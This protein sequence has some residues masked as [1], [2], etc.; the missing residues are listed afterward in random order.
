MSRFDAIVVGQGL[1]GTALT[2]RLLWRGLRV[3]VIDSDA[4][5]SPSKIAAGLIT[6]VTG[7]RLVL[8]P[9]FGRYFDT[10]VDHYRRV[11]RET[12][13]QVYQPTGA[14]RSF[15]DESERQWFSA[16]EGVLAESA[17]RLDREAMGYEYLTRFG[18]FQMPWAGRLD[19]QQYL[20]V[21]RTQFRVRGESITAALDPVADVNVNVEGVTIPRLDVRADRIVWC[22]GW[23]RSN[24]WYANIAFEPAKG[25]TLTVHIPGWSE[26]RTVHVGSVWVYPLAN[27]LCR[28]GATYD[29][30]HLDSVPTVAG[31]MEL[32]DRLRIAEIG[33]VSV[34][35][36]EAAVRPVTALRSPV[37]DLHPTENRV[38][39][40]T[41]L[42]SKGA[43]TSPFFAE[44]LVGRMLK[45]S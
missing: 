14:V 25:E 26:T 34:V 23:D 29:H 5:S 21:S 13:T 40:F 35:A 39:V 1:A 6:P 27:G 2:W 45:S 16:R 24:P 30:Q 38:G 36:H 15:L 41:G 11:E 32:L 31:R 44:Q 33:T 43:L 42:S 28:V 12:G 3:C 17:I 7:R 37:A 10:A 8:D 22:T 19:C 18:G 4:P 9:D 20:D